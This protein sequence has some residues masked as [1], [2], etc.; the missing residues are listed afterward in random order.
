MHRLVRPLHSI[1]SVF[2]RKKRGLS[3]SRQ[4]RISSN[5]HSHMIQKYPAVATMRNVSNKINLFKKF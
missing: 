1:P 2:S 5:S 4:C 3:F